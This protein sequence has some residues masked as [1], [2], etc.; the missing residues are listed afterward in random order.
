MFFDRPWRL[1]LLTI[2]RNRAWHRKFHRK[3]APPTMI[4]ECC[5]FRRW[6]AQRK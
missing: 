4:G 5:A 2:Q 1:R 6:T 3:E